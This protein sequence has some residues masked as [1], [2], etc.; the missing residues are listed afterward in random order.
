MSDTDKS[1]VPPT[2]WGDIIT[3]MLILMAVMGALGYLCNLAMKPFEAVNPT[4]SLVSLIRKGDGD[5]TAFH[6]ELEEGQSDNPDFVNTQ[7]LTGRTPLMW[8]VYAHFNNPERALSKDLERLYYV[9]ALLKTPRVEASLTDKDQFTALHWAAWSGMPYC[10]LELLTAGLEI[11]ARDTHGYTPLMLAALRGNA[12]VVEILL[13]RGADASLK[14]GEGKTALELVTESERAYNMRD[15]F[16]YK[17]IFSPER[18]KS[19]QRTRALLQNPPAPVSLAELRGKMKEAESRELARKAREEAEE[20]ADKEESREIKAE[21]QT[22]KESASAPATTAPDQLPSADP[23][24][25]VLPVGA[26]AE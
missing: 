24:P 25:E 23:Q 7:D 4:D 6:R 9:R 11:D 1:Q 17:L 3:D 10:S 21:E 5:K 14:N 26:D 13:Q 18:E 15:D 16:K 8:A 2:R 20:G 12:E 22:V 19:Y